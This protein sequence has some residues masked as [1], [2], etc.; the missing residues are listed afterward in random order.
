[1]AAKLSSRIWLLLVA[2]AL[3]CGER[4]P[5]LAHVDAAS[6]QSQQA[7]AAPPPPPPDVGD[8]ERFNSCRAVPRRK[9]TEVEKCQ[10][11][12]LKA[13]CTVGDDCLVSCLASPHGYEEGGGCGHV[14]FFG[15]HKGEPLPP[16]WEECAHVR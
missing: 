2:I 11:E 15:P 9:L 8:T 6:R 7:L 1:M 13:R 5:R 14:C 12:K 4:D 16:D 3:G 10:I